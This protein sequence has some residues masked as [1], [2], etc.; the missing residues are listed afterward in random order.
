M[1]AKKKGTVKYYDWRA[2][3]RLVYQ[4][5]MRGDDNSVSI[6]DDAPFHVITG[7]DC[8][9]SIFVRCDIEPLP[10]C[11]PYPDDE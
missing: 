10:D 2:L 7:T 8:H 5:M 1:N 9:N 6:D 3:V 4:D 11:K